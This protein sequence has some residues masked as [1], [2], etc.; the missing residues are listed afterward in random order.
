MICPEPHSQCGRVDR[1][2]GP[3][4]HPGSPCLASGTDTRW[5][6]WGSHHGWWCTGPE[7][8][9]PFH[10]HGSSQDSDTLPAPWGSPSTGPMESKA[11]AGRGQGLPEQRE[12]AQVRW[13]PRSPVSPIASTKMVQRWGE[14]IDLDLGDRPLPPPQGQFSLLV[15]SQIA[16]A[17]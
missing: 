11:M 9:T 16:L 3:A 13:A 1:G 4:Q 14:Q 7:A 8:D 6:C 5:S 17:D 12:Q 15:N 10:H 2:A